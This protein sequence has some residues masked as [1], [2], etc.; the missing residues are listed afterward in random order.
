MMPPLTAPHMP[1]VLE[2]P[3][4]NPVAIFGTK[5]D[6]ISSLSATARSTLSA[7]YMPDSKSS[8]L[9]WTVLSIIFPPAFR[10]DIASFVPGSLERE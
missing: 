7:Q 9:R 6:C 1:D 5:S 2:T 10:G 3:P 4:Q 8:P